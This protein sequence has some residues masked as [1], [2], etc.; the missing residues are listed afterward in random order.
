MANPKIPQS[1]PDLRPADFSYIREILRTRQVAGGRYVVEL[2]HMF[3]RC[4]RVR[5]AASASSGTA[6]LHLGLLALGVGPGDEVLVPSFTCAAVLQ[7]IHHVGARPKLLD[8][9]EEGLNVTGPIVRRHATKRAKA[10]IVTHTFGFPAPLDEVLEVGIP[11]IEDCALALGSTYD[12]RPVGSMGR[13]SVFSMY[14]TKVICAG[15]GGMVCASDGAII[16]RVRDLNGPDQREDWRPRYNY[17]LSDLAAGLALEQLRRLP[18]LIARRRAIAAR[19]VEEFKD[20]GVRFQ[21]PIPRGEPNYY[22]FVVRTPRAASII[23]RARQEGIWCDRPVFR[24]MHRYFD[25]ATRRQFPATE[26]VFRST[27]SIPI[28]PAL[29]DREVDRIARRMRRI[30]TT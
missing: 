14:A 18:E 25:S 19:Y 16:R 1:R 7:A 8:I 27:V 20:C 3:Q 17:K 21:Q 6:A 2:E 5:Y 9:D 15:E 24:P 13:L 4:V 29:S 30:L 12:G 28:Y 22:R 23:A 10:L 26:A 11:V